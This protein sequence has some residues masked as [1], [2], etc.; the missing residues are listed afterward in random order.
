MDRR[1]QKNKSSF[2]EN[3]DLGKLEKSSSTLSLEADGP[4]RKAAKSPVGIQPL[5]ALAAKGNAGREGSL[6]P[7]RPPDEGEGGFVVS[8]AKALVKGKSSRPKKPSR[9]TTSQE[10]SQ[11]R[12]QQASPKVPKDVAAEMADMA[13]FYKKYEGVRVGHCEQRYYTTKKLQRTAS[14]ISITE[15]NVKEI[16]DAK[17][18]IS[19][20]HPLLCNRPEE[21]NNIPKCLISVVKSLISSSVKGNETVFEFELKQNERLLKCQQQLNNIKA[22]YKNEIE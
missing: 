8:P 7:T 22:G 3:I 13:A 15:P 5:V 10:S 1:V 2:K 12:N 18:L 11:E 19:E 16:L 6:S 17:K 9:M 21:W 14:Q 20:K 4:A